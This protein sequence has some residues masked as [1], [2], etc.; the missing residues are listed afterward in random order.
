M[1]TTTCSP[2]V[3]KAPEYEMRGILTPRFIIIDRSARVWNRHD[4]HIPKHI[5]RS[6]PMSIRACVSR[7]FMLGD[8]QESLTKESTEANAATRDKLEDASGEFGG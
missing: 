7:A 8:K 3:A 4:Q 1:L 5:I 2:I 6:G